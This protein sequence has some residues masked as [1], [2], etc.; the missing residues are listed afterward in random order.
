[1]I[2]QDKPYSKVVQEGH[3]YFLVTYN[4]YGD[5]LYKKRIA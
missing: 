3:M 5:V 1:M 2:M 4:G